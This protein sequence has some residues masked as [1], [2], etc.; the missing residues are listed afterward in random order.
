[1]RRW[2]HHS[3]RVVAAVVIVVAVYFLAAPVSSADGP[4]PSALSTNTVIEMVPVICTD[5]KCISP[6]VTQCEHQ[7]NRFCIFNQPN[8]PICDTRHC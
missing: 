3:A 6:N 1:M 2:L 8:S 7:N 4:Y 5:S